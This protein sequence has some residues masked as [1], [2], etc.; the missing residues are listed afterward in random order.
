MS[1]KNLRQPFDKINE[2][3]NCG[4]IPE[5]LIESEFFGH[6]KGAFTG[7]YKEKA[8]LFDVAHNGTMFLDEIGELSLPMQIKLL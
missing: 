1:E 3:V 6:S 4:S 5:T 2:T 8:G 7:A